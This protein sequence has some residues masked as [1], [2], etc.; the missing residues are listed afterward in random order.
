MIVMIPKI[1]SKA[2][3]LYKQLQTALHSVQSTSLY[4]LICL[5]EHAPSQYKCHLISSYEQ[6]L[7]TYVYI[8]VDVHSTLQYPGTSFALV[9]VV[10]ILNDIG[11]VLHLCTLYWKETDD[12]L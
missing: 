11:T 10:C 5:K 6:A 12:H 9:P 7:K 1:C 8:E 2:A 3:Y 4:N